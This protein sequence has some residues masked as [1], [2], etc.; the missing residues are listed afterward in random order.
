LLYNPI[1]RNSDQEF[2]AEVDFRRSLGRSATGWIARQIYERF[3]S[4]EQRQREKVVALAAIL[5]G[6]AVVVI[7]FR[8]AKAA[9]GS[10]VVGSDPPWG[11]GAPEQGPAADVD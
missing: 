3:F 1:T 2:K 7:F 11:G 9:R 6:A 10:C 8:G 5:H 4:E